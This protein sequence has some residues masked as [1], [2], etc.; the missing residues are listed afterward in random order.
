MTSIFFWIGTQEIVCTATYEALRK[1][2]QLV[3]FK[4]VTEI[5]RPGLGPT[6]EWREFLGFA[7]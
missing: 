4:N 6:R 3:G 2:M 7:D 1:S 5:V